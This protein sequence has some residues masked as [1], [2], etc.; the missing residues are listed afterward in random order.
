MA[1]YKREMLETLYTN[2]L[3]NHYSEC[4]NHGHDWTRSHAHLFQRTSFCR[5]TLNLSATVGKAQLM[6]VPGCGEWLVMFHDGE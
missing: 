1:S 4:L 2:I 6:M 5:A 3:W